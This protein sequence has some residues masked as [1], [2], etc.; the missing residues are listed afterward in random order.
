MAHGRIDPL[1]FLVT[2]DSSLMNMMVIHDYFEELCAV[3][4]R[5]AL[6]RP[7]AYWS[8]PSLVSP[9]DC[10]RRPSGCVMLVRCYCSY[11]KLCLYLP[12]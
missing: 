11:M 10:S 4:Q 8:L 12:L 3:N 2:I 5:W 6:F 7:Y 1:L 9:I